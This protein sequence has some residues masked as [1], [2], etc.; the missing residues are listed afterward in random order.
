MGTAIRDERLK[1]ASR[2]VRA[3]YS[4]AVGVQVQ[5]RGLRARREVPNAFSYVI[6]YTD[7]IRLQQV[8]GSIRTVENAVCQ[9]RDKSET[10]IQKRDNWAS[11]ENCHFFPVHVVKNRDYPGNSGTDAHPILEQTLEMGLQLRGH[12]L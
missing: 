4:R 3:P 8:S 10:P 6:H 5:L 7:K 11:Q 2:R 1:G 12:T 9:C